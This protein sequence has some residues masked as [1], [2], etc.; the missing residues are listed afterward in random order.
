MDQQLLLLINRTWTNPTMDHVMVIFSSFDVWWPILLVGLVIAAIFGNFRVRAFLLVAG[1]TIGVT[2]G[3]VVDTIKGMVKRPR[4]HETV[5]GIRTL[6]LQKA[7]PRFLAIGQPLKEEFSEARLHPPTGNSFPSGHASNNFAVATVL[8]IFFRRWGWLLYLPAAL[9]SYSR[10]YTGSHWPLDV[11]VSAF[12]GIG[13]G[14]LVPAI[15]D[16]IWRRFGGRFFPSWH[17][18]HPT[19]FT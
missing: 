11:A 2:D 6:D 15:C 19:L 3:L 18:A 16:A 12:I 17:R 4:P 14:L 1:I 7:K 5:E 10:I 9:V 13:L 8:A